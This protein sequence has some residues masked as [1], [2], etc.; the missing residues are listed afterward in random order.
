MG[1][2]EFVVDL[3]S[4]LTLS[5]AGVV[6]VVLM[7]TLGAWGLG[8]WIL[9]GF[10]FRLDGHSRLARPV[11]ALALG[12]GALALGLFLAGTVAQAYQPAVMLPALAALALVGAHRLTH[13][14]WPTLR[15][16][17][18]AAGIAGAAVLLLTGLY[19]AEWLW[20]LSNFGSGSDVFT[21]HYPFVK[22]SIRAG[23]FSHPSY[24]PYG[25]DFVSS[26]NPALA[27]ML[28]LPGLLLADERAANL[29]HWLSQ[30]MMLAALYITGRGLQSA[31]AGLLAVVVYLSVGLLA[32]NPLEAQD[33]TLMAAYLVMSVYVT[34]ESLR[35][36][37]SRG[38]MLGGV[39]AGLM[40][41]TKYYAVPMFL[42]LA[43][44]VLVAPAASWRLRF[45]RA[46]RFCAPALLIF[47]PWVVYNLI[48]FHDPLPPWL[49]HDGEILH[50]NAT[51]WVAILRPFVLPMDTGFFAPTV[52]YYVSLFVPFSSGYRTHS[53]SVLFLIGM[54]WS[55]YYL[56]RMRS[57]E[58]LTVHVTFVLSLLGFVALHVLVGQSA[59]YKWALFPAVVYAISFG[60]L[61]DRLPR[62]ISGGLWM[63]AL[64]IA[65]LNYWYV[66]RPFMDSKTQDF[67]TTTQSA[68]WTEIDRYL[69]AN[70][71]P[72]A[73]ISGTDS[74]YYL[75]PDLTG[76]ME[77]T[78]TAFD[79][80]AE[81]RLVRQLG[82]D[83]MIVYP[84]ELEFDARLN[85]GWA[86]TWR[87]LSPDDSAAA[88]FIDQSQR[89]HEIRNQGKQAFLEKYGTVVHEFSNGGQLY[90]LRLDDEGP[91]P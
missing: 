10:R 78:R 49:R 62:R 85:A 75:R 25:F 22:F 60:L 1:L 77:S 39:L 65:G 32:Y 50:F 8:D 61:V 36:Q 59:H 28:W 31:R 18:R 9:A 45:G 26:Y 76:I 4:L 23:S 91:T 55:A 43:G 68:R 7:Q 29:V 54:P 46:A 64:V 71:E 70:A 67:P 17:P 63:L 12:W 83:Y 21:H 13:V 42:L 80:T 19:A 57:V 72:G 15:P 38:V 48:N 20:V 88:D 66:A 33:Y 56:W 51:A 24:L 79:W 40:L 86:A 44:L 73:V 14:Q 69:N 37:S 47:C 52:L 16:W 74:G 5:F 90:R 81:E 58:W 2:T 3:A 89:W 27:R 6:G 84:N 82:V 35:Q 53:L 87:Q 30:I 41:S 34:L 11:L